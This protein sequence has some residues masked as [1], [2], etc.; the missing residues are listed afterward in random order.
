MSK[1]SISSP[2]SLTSR[3]GRRLIPAG[4]PCGSGTLV[5]D[6]LLLA[7]DL[8]R[9]LWPLRIFHQRETE[10]ARRLLAGRLAAA[11]LILDLGCGRGSSLTGGW[12]GRVIGLDRSRRLLRHRRQREMLPLCADACRVPLA[13]GRFALV[14]AVGLAEYLPDPEPL[15]T[16]SARLLGPRGWL[17]LT[18]SP[19]NL[20]ARFRSLT[21]SPVHIHDE[22]M[23]CEL[24]RCCRLT[25]AGRIQTASQI[26]FLLRKEEIFQVN[27]ITPKEKL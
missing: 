13:P 26:A 25:L 2:S 8:G 14:L 22:V 19:P 15:L 20:L 23:L 24:F 1:S 9:R 11:P 12:P 18:V 16:E 27:R 4:L 3:A 21:G 6:V 10:A 7:R 17:L 5:D